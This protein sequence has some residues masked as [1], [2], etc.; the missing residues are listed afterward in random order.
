[1]YESAGAE[2]NLFSP[3]P[4]SRANIRYI[5]IGRR[6]AAPPGGVVGERI[7]V[8]PAVLVLVLVAAAAA[9]GRQ[10]V[11]FGGR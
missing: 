11:A 6:P 7:D 4:A 1:M 5:R 2:R 10:P 3:I 9:L 8:G